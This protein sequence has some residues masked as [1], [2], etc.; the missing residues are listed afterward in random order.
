MEYLNIQLV[1]EILEKAKK[2]MLGMMKVELKKNNEDYKN[3]IT[4]NNFIMQFDTLIITDKKRSCLTSNNISL[5]V[6]LANLKIN[7]IYEFV[8]EYVIYELR[9]HYLKSDFLTSIYTELINKTKTIEFSKLI[10]DI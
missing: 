2:V 1:I 9:K 7:A 3:I 5:Q 6:S 4:I 8:K 10:E